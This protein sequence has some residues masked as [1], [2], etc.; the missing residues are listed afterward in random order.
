[1][2]TVTECGTS[3]HTEDFL[4]VPKKLYGKRDCIQNEKEERQLLLAQHPLSDYFQLTG[5]VVYQ[6][7]TPVARAALTI[8][9]GDP[10]A[11]IGFFESIDDVSCSRALFAV[12]HSYAAMQDKRMITGPVDA[13]FW[14]RYRLKT[15]HFDAAPYIGEPY[16]KSYYLNLFLD[17]G[18]RVSQKYVSNIYKNR[19]N[20]KEAANF[21]RDYASSKREGYKIV[22]PKPEEFDVT[23]GYIYDMLMELYSDFPIFKHVSKED[24]RKHFDSYR[25]ILD[26]SLVK[27]AYHGGQPVGF[28]VGLPDYGNLLYGKITPLTKLRILLKKI[29]SKRYIMLYLGVRKAHQGHGLGRAITRAAVTRVFMKLASCVGAL[30]IEG[31]VTEEYGKTNIADQYHYVLLEKEIQ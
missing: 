10:A 2:Y 3:Q 15:D 24:F 6:D 7:G 23:L 1:M 9:D 21:N 19:I 31:K 22:S 25:Y 30:I 8:Y 26:Y 14:I 13:S 16:N 18:Y 11:Y 28:F 20:L 5:F 27:I 12:I 17:S 4:S 29:R